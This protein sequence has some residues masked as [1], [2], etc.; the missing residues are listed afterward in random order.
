M[1]PLQS[2]LKSLA[3]QGRA[4]G[5]II[6]KGLAW[7]LLMPILVFVTFGIAGLW[8]I[9]EVFQY[10]EETFGADFSPM[11]FSVG[12]FALRIMFFVI[13]GIWG[14]Y[15]VVIIMSPF[16]AYVSEKTEQILNGNEYPFDL[17]QIIKDALRGILL[18]IRNFFMEI[19][20]SILVLLSVAV[21][22]IGPVIVMIGTPVILFFVSAY[23]YGFSFIDYTNERRKLSINE[24]VNFVK[25]HKGM[26][27]GHGL[28]FSLLMYIPIIGSFL[29]AIFA[30]VSTVAATIEMVENKE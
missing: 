8:S 15:I 18:A 19:L 13:F 3:M 12:L 21:P 24:S 29:S 20:I 26:A 10:V 25:N 6:T 14:G 2:L 22:V 27:V 7:T 17:V 9:G 11:L 5:F 28:I 4:F 16:M 23:F 30:I 1:S